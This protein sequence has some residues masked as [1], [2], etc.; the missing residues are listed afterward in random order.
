MCGIGDAKGA[1]WEDDMKELIQGILVYIVIVSALRGLITNP[2]Y[3]QYFQFFSGIVMI[4]LLLSPVLS[5]FDFES[6]WYEVLEEKILQMDLS[7]IEEEMKIADDRFA[8]MLE[9]KYQETAAGQIKAMAE[10]NGISV[11]EAGVELKK[12]KDGWEIEEISITRKPDQDDRQELSVEA[13]QIDTKRQT[14]EEDKSKRAKSL[15][16]Q[17]CSYFVIGEDRV[18]IWK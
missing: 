10:Q 11:E 16:K 4:L 6:K 2:K 17:I 9:K 5:V 13:V 1:A 12:G 14:V 8:E 15:Q 18:H 7:E 3:S